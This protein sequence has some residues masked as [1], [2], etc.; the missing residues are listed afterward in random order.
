MDYKISE[1]FAALTGFRSFVEDMLATQRRQMGAEIA[2]LKEELERSKVAATQ[3][4]AAATHAA[5][6]AETEI[7]RLKGELQKAYK[8]STDICKEIAFLSNQAKDVLWT[9]EGDGDAKAEVG[10][11][12]TTICSIATFNSH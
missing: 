6:A 5:S 4:E 2:A 7:A 10:A 9:V 3:K 8:W 12:L 1:C 11:L